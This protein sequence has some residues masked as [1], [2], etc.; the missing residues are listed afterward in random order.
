MKPLFSYCLAILLAGLVSCAE[1]ARKEPVDYVNPNT[2]TIGH[3]LVATNSMTQLPHGMVQVGQNPYPPLADR[4]LADRISGFSIRALPR[5]AT[6]P[7]AEIMATTGAPAVE[8]EEYASGFDHDF[9]TVTPYYTRLLLEDY[10]IDAAMTVSQHAS[11]YKFRFPQSEQANI[12]INN[13]RT[14]R[15]AGENRIESTETVDSTQTAYYYAEFSKPFSS[16]ITWNDSSKSEKDFQ[17]GE[18]IGACVSFRTS[19]DEEIMVKIGVSFISMEQAKKNL[20][21]EIPDWDFEKTKND[22]RKIWNDA[23]GR[24]RV[25]GG[26]QRQKTIFYTALYR[27]MLGSQSIDLTE[28]GGRYYSRF[29]K[30]VHETG[31][32]NFYKVGS[33]WGSHHSLFPLCLLIEPE[34]QND[35]MRSYVRMQQEGDWLV[36]SG[37]FRNMIGRHETATITDAYMKGYRDFDIETAYEAMKRNSKEATMLSRPST[38]DWRGTELDKVYW[39]K[40][41]FPAKPSDQPEW[42]KE[43]GFGRQSVAITLENCYDDWCMS[44]LAKE[45]DKEEDYQY[46]LKRALNYQNVFDTA[47]GFM[48]PKTADGRWIEPFDPIWS[49]GQGGREFYTENNGGYFDDPDFRPYLTDSPVPEGTPVKGAVLICPGGAFQFRSDQPEGV[50]VAEALSALGYQSFVVDYR[51]RPYT[52]QEG[53]LDLA[54][55]VRFVRAHAQAYGIDPSDIAAMGFSAGGILSGEM[56]LHY[57]GAVDPTALDASHTPDE[58]DR[59]SAD[60]AACGM[61]YSFYGRLSVGTTDVELLRSGDL[62]PTFYC[63]GTR[64]P[65]YDQFLANTDAAEAAGVAVE[66]LQLD[67]M[68][69]GF[70]AS[71][72]WIPAYDAWLTEVFAAND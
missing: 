69:R 5:Y 11:F 36:N 17:E 38:N 13:N 18:R 31:G 67:G 4:Y 27:V 62:P 63:Y 22:A 24:I 23:L 65:F 12:L 48:R 59:I 66:R 1:S 56:L 58:L 55:A 53:A 2:G 32:H 70:G 49:G 34:I 35:L 10:D 52:Q 71:G 39:E 44:I 50:D 7:L 9:E 21:A 28:Q 68:P 33:N 46:Y 6:K 45:L 20:T 41:F 8:A 29:D 72:G 26:T 25:E 60:A 61:I 16:A 3:L 30:Q 40:G 37:G 19:R 47:T 15:I 43:V 57:D 42:V 51:L 54:R 14:I 64:D